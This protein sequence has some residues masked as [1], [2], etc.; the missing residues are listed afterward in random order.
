MS[1]VISDEYLAL[2]VEMHKN[3]NY[4]VASLGYAPIVADYFETN[5]LESVADYGAGKC[6]LRKGLI[7]AG[8]KNF[9]YFP[10]DPAFPDYGSFRSADLVCCIDVLEHIEDP[11]LDNVLT[12]L[13]NKMP[14]YGFLTVH[15]GPAQKVLADGR[16]AH[17]IQQPFEWWVRRMTPYFEFHHM[18]AS[19]DSKGFW[20]LVTSKEAS[21]ESSP[22]LLSRCHYSSSL[23]NKKFSWFKRK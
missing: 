9:D 5:K 11:C 7:A 12:E 18:Q 14:R 6:N 19:E 17:L 21:V 13:A 1:S 20:L 2:Q 16:N 22:P 3:P 15:T 4:G 10:Y 23:H 8:V